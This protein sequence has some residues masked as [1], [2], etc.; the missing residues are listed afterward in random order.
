[1][2]STLKFKVMYEEEFQKEM[3]IYNYRAFDLYQKPV[4]SLAIWEMKS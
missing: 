3:Y 2:L 4:I 1:M